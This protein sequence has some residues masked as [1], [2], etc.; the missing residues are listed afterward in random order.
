MDQLVAEK[1]RFQ[2]PL[3]KVTKRS[4][5]RQIKQ[6][7]QELTLINKGINDRIKSCEEKSKRSAC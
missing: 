2:V 7:K 6:L 3:S 5:K 4:I 1:C